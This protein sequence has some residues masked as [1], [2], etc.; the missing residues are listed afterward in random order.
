MGA[1]EAKVVAAFTVRVLLLPLLPNTVLPRA[2][3]A[4]LAV[5]RAVVAKV[6]TALTVRVW[7]PVVPR[8]VLPAAVRVLP[9]LLRVTPATHME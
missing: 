8:T 7:L 6:V 1:V 4:A 3:K 9:V 2:L 5:I